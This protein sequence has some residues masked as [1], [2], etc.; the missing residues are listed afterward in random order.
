VDEWD[1]EH[2]AGVDALAGLAIDAG[3]ARGVV[4]A[5]DPLLAHAEPG[6]AGCH[7]QAH[8]EE[9]CRLAGGDAVDH[10]VAVGDLDHAGTRLGQLLAARGDQLHHRI[11]VEIAGRDLGLGLDYRPQAI[12]AACAHAPLSAAP[13]SGFRA[14]RRA[15]RL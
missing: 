8:A 13:Y 4:A 3:V 11:E 7:L 1:A 2:R 14:E 15:R 10:L 12:A 6:E 5:Q 9:G